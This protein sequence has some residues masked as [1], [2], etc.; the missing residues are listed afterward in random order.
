MLFFYGLLN[1]F[2]S[3]YY[4]KWIIICTLILWLGYIVLEILYNFYQNRTI[5]KTVLKTIKS[6]EKTSLLVQKTTHF[7]LEC[8]NLHGI[9]RLITFLP[10][11][12]C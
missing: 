3:K 1:V 10:N 8:N 5:K 11:N 2:F 9:Y 12:L 6:M 4:N 7:I